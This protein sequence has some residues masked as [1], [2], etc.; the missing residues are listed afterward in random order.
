MFVVPRDLAAVVNSSVSR[1]I[2]LAERKR[3]IK[4]LEGAQVDH[5]VAGWLARVEKETVDTLG[6]LGQATATELARRV[7]GL[8]VQIAFGEGTKWAGRVG[9]STRMLFLLATEGRIIRGRPRG[10]WL[11]SMYAWAPMETWLGSALEKIPVE[12]AQAELVR[13]YLAT[14]GPATQRDVQ[15]WTGWT[16]AATR[17]VLAAVGAAE[18]ET[19]SGRGLVLPKDGA[20]T[21][22]V[23]PWAALLPALDTT[24]MGWAERD[25]YLGD[26]VTALFDRNGNAGP[27]VWS[28]GRVVGGWA[29]RKS[30]EVVVR[31]LEDIG[32]EAK[33]KVESEGA[34]IERWLGDSRVIPRFRTPLEKELT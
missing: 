16:V 6:D 11:S 22:A 29:Q 19:E 2:G 1:A 20:Q 18:V 21:E 7:E 15:W 9:V 32:S 28:D 31:L 8:R 30:G 14:Y 34:R 12:E 27:T 5:D 23:T 24:I 25:W 13:R 26:H 17:Q 10:T 33:V 4:M 3:L